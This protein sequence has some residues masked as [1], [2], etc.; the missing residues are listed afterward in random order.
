MNLDI[1]S[2]IVLSD[3][4]SHGCFDTRNPY[5]VDRAINRTFK[6]EDRGSRATHGLMEWIKE[7][8][9]CRTIG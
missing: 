3:G 2:F 1:T 7:T 6:L 4:A 8:A 5:L 9:D